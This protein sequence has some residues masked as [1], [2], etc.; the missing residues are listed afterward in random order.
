MSIP[1]LAGSGNIGLERAVTDGILMYEPIEGM[2]IISVD[3]SWE[4]IFDADTTASL[5]VVAAYGQMAAITPTAANDPMP[6]TGLWENV[7][8]FDSIASFNRAVTFT[9]GALAGDDDTF[10]FDYA[11]VYRMTISGTLEHN[12]FPSDSREFSVRLFNVTT[13]TG[14]A[15]VAT[16][17]ISRNAGTTSFDLTFLIEIV[18]AQIGDLFVMQIGNAPIAITG[19]VWDRAVIALNMVSEWK[20]APIGP[21]GFLGQLGFRKRYLNNIVKRQ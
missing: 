10:N 7:T 18:E 8:V 20:G 11:G 9:L 2:M 19:V 14:S 17:T 1:T 6:L 3:D 15:A 5:F 4:Y 13:A 21:T 16:S 12:L